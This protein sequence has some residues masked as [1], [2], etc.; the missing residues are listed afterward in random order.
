MEYVLSTCNLTKRFKKH[1]AVNNVSLH[2]R[3][4][5]IYGFIGRNG[6]R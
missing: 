6:A 4:G 3:R 5:E 2:I 1:L